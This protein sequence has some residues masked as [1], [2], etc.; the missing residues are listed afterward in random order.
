MANNGWKM[1][2]KEKVMAN[3]NLK[4]GV[5]YKPKYHKG[6]VNDHARRRAGSRSKVYSEQGRRNHEAIF[7]RRENKVNFQLAAEC[8]SS[9]Q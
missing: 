6:D 5:G 3:L 2:K 1:S 9:A 4:T 8:H 7:G